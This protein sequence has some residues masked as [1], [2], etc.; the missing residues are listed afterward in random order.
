MNLSWLI[1]T[2]ATLSAVKYKYIRQQNIKIIHDRT[3]I[4][5][6]GGSIEAIGYVNLKLQVANESIIHI[7]LFFIPCHALRQE[8]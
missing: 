1:D 6:I 7:F 2:G 8:F 3:N 4:N 5:G